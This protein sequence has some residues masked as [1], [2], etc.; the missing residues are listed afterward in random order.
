MKP[1]DIFV[2]VVGAALGAVLV[3]N[4]LREKYQAI[5][6]EEID[7]MKEHYEGWRE[8]PEESTQEEVV[9]DIVDQF[10]ELDRATYQDYTKKYTPKEYVENELRDGLYEKEDDEVEEE[11]IDYDYDHPK[12]F[13]I[14]KPFQISFQ[15]FDQEAPH[16]EKLSLTFYEDEV[17]TDEQEEV[18]TDILGTVGPNALFNFGSNPDDPDVVYVRNDRLTADFEVTRFDMSYSEYILGIKPTNESGRSPKRREYDDLE[19]KE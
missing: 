4:L 19:K 9:E 18:I 1:R 13:K 15:E 17:L 8:K 12:T 6:Q 3:S 14:R 5:S 10:S 2:F 11:P 7:A 16:Y